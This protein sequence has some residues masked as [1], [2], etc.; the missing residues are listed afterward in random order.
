[1]KRERKKSELPAGADTL[2]REQLRSVLRP[3]VLP[4]VRVQWI[5]VE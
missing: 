3:D 4:G 5:W 1:M 2:K